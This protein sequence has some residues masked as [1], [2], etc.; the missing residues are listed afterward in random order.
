VTIS[1]VQNKLDKDGVL[2]DKVVA[3]QLTALGTTLAKELKQRSF[4]K[5][6]LKE[7]ELK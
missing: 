1:A 4:L 5:A 7:E 6:H 3:D 2:Q